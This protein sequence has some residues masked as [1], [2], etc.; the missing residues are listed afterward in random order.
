MLLVGFFA[1]VA[2]LLSAASLYALVSFT[3]SQ[4]TREIGIRTALGAQPGAIVG[5]IAKRAFLQL[6]GGIAAGV[7]MGSIFLGLAGNDTAARG[8]NWPIMLPTIAGFVFVVGMGAC[9]GPTLRG[10]RI[11]PVEALREG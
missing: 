8:A 3:V 11:R 2:V 5:A 6:S 4:R 1:G 9:V 10:L 7:V